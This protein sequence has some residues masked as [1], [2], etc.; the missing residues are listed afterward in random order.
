MLTFGRSIDSRGRERRPL[1]SGEYRRAVNE[2]TQ[3][4]MGVR[5]KTST[6]TGMSGSERRRA[7]QRARLG[8][9]D[10]VSTETRPAM[11]STRPSLPRPVDDSATGQAGNAWAELDTEEGGGTD[12]AALATEDIAEQQVYVAQ[13]PIHRYV[14]T[15]VYVHHCYS[16]GTG[17]LAAIRTGTE[18]KT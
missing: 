14:C 13:L 10:V 16:M 1:A 6:T 12:T 11:A 17:A 15:Y 7:A 9:Q 2:Q 3:A 18:A 8:I 4:L 5:N